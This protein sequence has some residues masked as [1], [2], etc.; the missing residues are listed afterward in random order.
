MWLVKTANSKTVNGEG[1]HLTAASCAHM[2]FVCECVWVCVSVFMCVWVRQRETIIWFV[3]YEFKTFFLN[4]TKYHLHLLIQIA[5]DFK[6]ND[7]FAGGGNPIKLIY[8][9]K[10]LN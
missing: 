4:W 6:G 10:R 1:D 8:S 7:K 2:V 3:L 5:F 9:Q